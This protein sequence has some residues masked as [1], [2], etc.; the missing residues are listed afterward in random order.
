MRAVIRRFIAAAQSGCETPDL[1]F[2]RLETTYSPFFQH[3]HL[4]L[5]PVQALVSPPSGGIV[6][7]TSEVDQKSFEV[8]EFENFIAS[9]GLNKQALQHHRHNVA[10]SHD[11]LVRI[12]SGEREVEITVI[13]EKGNHVHNFTVTA[14]P[15]VLAAVKRGIQS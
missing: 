1:Q 2:V 8:R 15:S 3:Y 14:P 11:Q 5:L 4:L 9:S 7:R 12:A 6:L 10:I 13:S